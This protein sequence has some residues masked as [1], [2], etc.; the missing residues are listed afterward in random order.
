VARIQQTTNA[1]QKLRRLLPVREVSTE[2]VKFDMQLCEN[3]D[4]A[5]GESQHGSLAGYEVKEYLHRTR[6]AAMRLL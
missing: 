2:D 1:V 5:G 4:I 3:P 6:R